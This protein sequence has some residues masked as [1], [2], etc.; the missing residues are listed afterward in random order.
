MQQTSTCL[1]KY[2]HNVAIDNGYQNANIINNKGC[3]HCQQQALHFNLARKADV[4]IWIIY[5]GI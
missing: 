5:K 3:N 2:K 1:S 4:S